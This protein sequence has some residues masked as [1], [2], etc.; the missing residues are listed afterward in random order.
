M[1]NTP[2]APRPVG[3]HEP[4]HDSG[5]I[6]LI[7]PNVSLANWKS[8]ALALSRDIKAVQVMGKPKNTIGECAR[9][10]CAGCWPIAQAAL[11]PST[12]RK[13]RRRCQAAREWT[14]F[15]KA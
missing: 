12:A 3:R 7:V 2:Q 4:S 13:P 10:A 5:W 9:W 11:Q 6:G 15:A 14:R 1:G 8:W